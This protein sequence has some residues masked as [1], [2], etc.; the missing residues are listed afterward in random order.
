MNSMVVI[1]FLRKDVRFSFLDFPSKQ[2]ELKVSIQNCR[3]PSAEQ[4]LPNDSKILV[5]RVLISSGTTL[6][7]IGNTAAENISTS[8]EMNSGASEFEVNA[9]NDNMIRTD[10]WLTHSIQPDNG[11]TRRDD[12]NL[13][14]DL[15]D[16]RL[17]MAR[18]NELNAVVENCRRPSAEHFLE[19]DSKPVLLRDT[20]TDAIDNATENRVTSTEIK[21][22]NDS[23][24]VDNE[25]VTHSTQLESG[26]ALGNE[27]NLNECLQENIETQ[28]NSAVIATG[29]AVRISRGKRNSNVSS[30]SVGSPERRHP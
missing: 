19:D 11:S 12:P 14:L 15:Q 24:E 7:G 18:E 1:E 20:M 26:S 27:S 6:D 30:N 16:V 9:N 10:E 2:N 25:A 8:T 5:P 21:Q 17:F 22:E 29:R 28:H 13:G 4:T 23:V 3:R